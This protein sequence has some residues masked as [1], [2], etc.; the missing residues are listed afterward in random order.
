M[1]ESNVKNYILY[2]SD[3]MTFQKRQNYFYYDKNFRGG[4]CQELGETKM[5]SRT[6]YFQG[7]ETTSCNTIKLAKK[8]I[9][10]FP[11]DV[12]ENLEQTLQPT[13]YNDGDISLY[14]YPNLECTTWGVNS[15]VNY[16]LWMII[17]GQ[18]MF[19]SCNKCTTL[20]GNGDRGRGYEFLWAGRIWETPY[21]HFCCEP[22]ISIKNKVC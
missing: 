10:V 7:S 19:I 2:D 14:I 1:K 3:Y 5:S 22:K 15:D 17:M 21:F 11:Q 16:V 8:L 20:V 13:Q 6:E 12:M 18:C 9:W 4:N